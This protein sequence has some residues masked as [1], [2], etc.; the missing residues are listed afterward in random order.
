METATAGERAGTPPAELKQNAL[1]YLSNLVIGVAS[2]APAYSLA[3]TLG[4]VVAVAGVGVHAPAV[5]LVSFV[6]ILFVA[7]AYRYLN[8]ADPDAGTSFSWV[9]RAMG[10]H[11]GWLNGWAIFVADVIVMATLAQ[12]AGRYTFLLV[13]WH[14]AA[15][16]N[17]AQIAAAVVWIALMTWICWR[18]IE[19]SARIQTA[20][21]SAEIAILAAFSAVAL[22]KVYLNHPAGSLTPQLDWFNPF[23]LGWGALVDGILL[24][25]FIYW[26]WDSGVAV[27]EESE[28]KAE[29]PGRAAVVSTLLLL[30]IYLVVSAAAQAYSGTA[31]LTNNPDDVLSVLGTQV[32]GSPWDKLLIV[33]VLTSASA[34]TQTTILPTA[35]TMLSMARQRAIPTRFAHIHPQ[36]QTPDTATLF[37]G[38]LSIV[39]TVGVMALNPAQSVLGDSITALGFA[40]C[41]YYG[42]T[43]IA[44]AI[45]FRHELRR[46]VRNLVLVGIVPLLGGLM[47]FGIFVKALTYYSKAGANYAPPILGIQVPIVIGIGSLLLGVVAMLLATAPYRAF[48]RR[49]PEVA[50]PGFLDVP[51]SGRGGAP[52]STPSS[53]G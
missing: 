40:I 15:D 9:T 38:G 39:W 23:A 30:A 20:L 50:P 51:T 37:M 49:K 11:L 1:G 53:A 27:N 33:A 47:L 25:V 36:H 26:G 44:C 28:D 13:G 34:S 17:G 29:G 24:G 19:L 5:L 10:P 43:G 18:G 52:A 35:R 41:F 12:I 14:S 32:F 6:P 22:T 46:S 16:S 45:Y 2:T 21:L 8:K 4:F 31:T 48:F 7:A 42:F 3:A